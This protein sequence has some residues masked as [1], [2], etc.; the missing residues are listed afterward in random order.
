M[1][2]HS[3]HAAGE[4]PWKFPRKICPK[5]CSAEE[6]RAAGHA[7]PGGAGASVG[8]G[9]PFRSGIERPPTI[10]QFSR[11]LKIIQSFQLLY[12]IDRALLAGVPF[13]FTSRSAVSHEDATNVLKC[14]VFVPKLA[15]WP[16]GT[17]NTICDRR[18]LRSSSTRT[19]SRMR[20][21]STIAKANRAISHALFGTTTPCSS[22][23]TGAVS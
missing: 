12:G 5:R 6:V 16:E 20:L 14:T 4:P 3:F 1:T 23:L 8:S 22:T 13:R 18:S 21:P 2:R 11:K 17:A 7:P 15:A 19:G 9:D 10:I